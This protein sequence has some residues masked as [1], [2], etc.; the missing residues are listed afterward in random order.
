MRKPPRKRVLLFDADIIAY[1]A[2]ATYQTVT[3]FLDDENNV[4]F[5]TDPGNIEDA[6]S[7]VDEFITDVLEKLKAEDFVL[8]F[9]DPVLNWRKEILP[10]YKGN[11]DPSKKPLHLPELRAWMAEKW[12]RTY[13]KPK[14]EGDDA[15]GIIATSGNSIVAGEKIIVSIDKDLRTIPGLVY[16]PGKDTAPLR[17]SEWEADHWHAMQTLMGD[18]T[19]FYKGCPGIG[20]KKAA[21][22]LEDSTPDTLWPKVLET[23]LEKGLTEEDALV[24]ARVA[25][26]C[27]RS[28]YDFDKQEVRLWVP[29]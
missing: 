26:I 12:P 17:V 29:R 19:D 16:R 2:C 18:P 4:V 13:Q 24:Q 10:T 1:Q 7:Y 21:R 22:I 11:R 20:P 15:L 27:R 6:Q 28:E 3:K 23:F 25:R 5:S 14:L 9:S 8:A